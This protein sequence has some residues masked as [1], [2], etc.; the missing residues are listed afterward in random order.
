LAASKSLAKDE[1]PVGGVI[2]H[3][4]FL[5]VFRIVLDTGCTVYGDKFPNADLA[6]MINSPVMLVHGTADQIVPFY[7]SEKLYEALPK[8]CRSKPLF[9]EGMSHN[10]VHAAVRPLF[11]DR[12]QEFLEEHIIP[13]AIDDSTRMNS[14]AK[15][16]KK[17]LPFELRDLNAEYETA[18]SYPQ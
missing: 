1:E 9:I 18:V 15:T 7:H 4:P 5:S 8:D 11:V 16:V 6:P 2:L 3:A 13:F 17:K 12:I 14:A 10:N